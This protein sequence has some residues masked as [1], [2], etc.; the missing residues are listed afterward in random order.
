MLKFRKRRFSIFIAG[1]LHRP[2]IDASTMR[3]SARQ[4]DAYALPRRHGP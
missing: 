4:T 2:A 3:S 1:R